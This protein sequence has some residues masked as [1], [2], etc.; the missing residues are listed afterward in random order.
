MVSPHFGVPDALPAVARVARAGSPGADLGGDR[1]P[2]L[3]PEASL[4]GSPWA[5][6]L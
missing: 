5:V 4:A 3:G 6:V 2:S 1:T